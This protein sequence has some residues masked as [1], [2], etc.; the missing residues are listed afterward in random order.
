M[1]KVLWKWI[2]CSLTNAI[3]TNLRNGATASLNAMTKSNKKEKYSDI[4]Y[5]IKLADKNIGFNGLF[6]TFPY[7][8]AFLLRRFLER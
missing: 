8:T 6:Y 3:E 5:G 7:F 2:L 4:K 1:K